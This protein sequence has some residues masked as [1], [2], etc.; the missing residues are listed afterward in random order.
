MAKVVTTFSRFQ[1][2]TRTN[3]E[4]LEFMDNTYKCDV[5]IFMSHTRDNVNVIPYSVKHH[6]A[7]QLFPNHRDSFVNSEART[8]VQ[9]LDELRANYDEI[10]FVC[11]SENFETFSKLIASYS[12]KNNIKIECVVFEPKYKEQCSN[13]IDFVRADNFDDF[14]KYS[15]LFADAFDIKLAFTVIKGIISKQ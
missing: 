6:M 14:K 1:G 11:L 15:P 7:Q 5:K 13:I 2:F 10:V 8:V 4:M 9:V 3:E 12:I